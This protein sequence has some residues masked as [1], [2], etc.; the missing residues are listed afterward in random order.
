MKTELALL[1]TNDGNPVMS[2]KQVADLLGITERTAE[3]KIY[4]KTF[5][6]PVF[7]LGTKWAAHVSDLAKH[8]DEQREDA[9]RLLQQQRHTA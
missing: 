7:K 4:A 9:T 3:N 1:M 6:I 5:P 2:L 8:I